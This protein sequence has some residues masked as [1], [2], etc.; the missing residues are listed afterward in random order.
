[1]KTPVEIMLFAMSERHSGTRSE[2]EAIVSD[3]I[4]ALEAAGYVIVHPDQ[5]TEGMNSVQGASFSIDA[6]L[7]AAHQWSKG[8]E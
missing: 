2:A 1:M 7:R 5:V 8:S 4:A 6:F 3:Q